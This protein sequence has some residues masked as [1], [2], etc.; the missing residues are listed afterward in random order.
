MSSAVPTAERTRPLSSKAMST[1]YPP[2]GP[3]QYQPQVPTCYRHPDRQTYVQC[4]RCGRYICPECMRDAAVG[5]QCVECVQAGAATVRQPRT[6]FGGRQTG[7]TPVVTYALIAINV[8]DVHRADRRRPA[9]NASWCC[10]HRPSPTVRCGGSSPRRSC[11]TA[12]RTS[13]STCWRCGWSGRRW[14]GGWAGPGSCRST[15]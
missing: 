2:P 7:D 12:S 11:T 13:C 9:W 8:A 5:H 6:M 15:S 3:P 1:P 14:R 10:G 4:T